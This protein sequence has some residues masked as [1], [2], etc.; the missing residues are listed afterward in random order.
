MIDL[1][2]EEGGDAQKLSPFTMKRTV[3]ITHQ[4][5][6]ERLDHTLPCLLLLLLPS[7]SAHLHPVNQLMHN[8]NLVDSYLILMLLLHLLRTDTTHPHPFAL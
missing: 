4:T 3:R 5:K 1:E 6:M 2:E 7:L 8:L